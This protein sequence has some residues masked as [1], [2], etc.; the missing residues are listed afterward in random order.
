VWPNRS[1]APFV[2]P[3][4]CRTQEISRGYHVDGVS[5]DLD[6]DGL[7]LMESSELPKIE[8]MMPPMMAVMMS[9]IGG[10]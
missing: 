2:T 8:A 5:Q 3:V 9:A 10:N 6:L 7:G 4:N 1:D